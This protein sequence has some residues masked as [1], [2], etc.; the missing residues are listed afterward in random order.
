M[1]VPDNLRY[2]SDHEWVLVDGD[3]AKVGITDYAQ[4][5]LG[6]VVFVDLPATGSAIGAA[7]SFGEVESTKSVSELYAPVSGEI[8]AVNDALVDTPEKLNEDPYGE[9][10]IV[11]ISI[12]DPTELDGLLDADGYRALI[13]G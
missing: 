10:W 9:G 5:A 8:A 7:D 1:N 12:S 6:D 13:E 4:D 2:S 3:T 11:T